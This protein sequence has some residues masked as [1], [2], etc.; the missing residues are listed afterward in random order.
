MKAWF[1]LF[2]AGLLETGWAVG[3]KYSEGFARFWPRG[4]PPWPRRAGGS[5]AAAVPGKEA[6]ELRQG[7]ATSHAAAAETAARRELRRH[8]APTHFGTTFTVPLAA[9]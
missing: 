4:F 6:R 2:I 5:P 9:S 7:I 1:W 8:R 3:L